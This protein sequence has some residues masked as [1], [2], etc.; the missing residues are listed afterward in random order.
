MKNNY[1]TILAAGLLI[2]LSISLYLLYSG[3]NVKTGFIKNTDVYNAFD[4]KKELEIKLTQVKNQRKAILDSLVMELKMISTDL[5]YGKSKEEREIKKFE[6][7]KE[8]YLTKQSE[9][10]EDTERLAEQYTQQIWKQ[11]N[12]Y[13]TDFGKE[14]DYAFIHGASGD[15]SLMYAKDNFDLTEEMI[16]YVNLKYK[17]DKK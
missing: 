8:E 4:L 3:D 5:Q 11:I 7:K 1:K 14:Q 17:G 16:I 13:V 6:Y 9:F 15:G 10:E 12:Q 2:L